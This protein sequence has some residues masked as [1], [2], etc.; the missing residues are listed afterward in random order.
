MIIYGNILTDISVIYDFHSCT[1][2][3]F[4]LNFNAV[5]KQCGRVGSWRGRKRGVEISNASRASLCAF[6]RVFS[7]KIFAEAQKNHL[8]H[9]PECTVLVENNL[10]CI[11]VT[12][13]N[14][15]FRKL[16]FHSYLSS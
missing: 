8:V 12:V 11:L 14:G 1:S 3:I 7:L 16:I 5:F 4:H 2:I 9:N 13:C 10:E 6:A 15:I